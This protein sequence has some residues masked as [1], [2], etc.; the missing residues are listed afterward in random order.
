MTSPATTTTRSTATTRIA[1]AGKVLA[2]AVGLL[3][4]VVGVPWALITWLGNPV[5]WVTALASPAQQLTDTAVLQ[6]LACVVWIAWAHWAWCVLL[7]AVAMARGAAMPRLRWWTAPQH[8]LARTL[9]SWV[10]L[11]AIAIPTLAAKAPHT[12]AAPTPP[13]STPAIALVHASD[14]ATP[15]TS[16]T[17]RAADET[18]TVI[19][20]VAAT[21]HVAAAQKA[22]HDDG[23]ARYDVRRGDSLWDIAERHLGNGMRWREIYQLNAHRRQPDGHRLHD[24]NLIYPGW[25]LVL[26]ADATG[27]YHDGD[28][29]H[30]GDRHEARRH[31]GRD[32]GKDHASPSARPTAPTHTTA[33]THSSNRDGQPTASASPAPTEASTPTIGGHDQRATSPHSSTAPWLA[34]TLAAGVLAAG[35]GIGVAGLRRRQ[36]RHRRPGRRIKLPGPAARATERRLRAV[37]RRRAVDALDT[38]LRGLSATLANTT[39][40]MPDP[41]AVRL[42][43]TR[44]DLLLA[45]EADAPQ[46]WQ[47]EGRLWHL[48]LPPEPTGDTN[49]DD[50]ASPA[51]GVAPLLTGQQDAI[52][53][54][55]ALATVGTLGEAGDL[56]MLD[57][58]RVG[59]LAVEGDRAHAAGLLR[60]LAAEL[61]WNTWSDDVEIILVGDFTTDD[62]FGDAVADQLV[63]LNPERIR[64]A[65]TFGEVA[66]QIEHR[67]DSI[68]EILDRHD[69][70]DT[71]TGRVRDIAT[72][73]WTPQIVILA[74]APPAGEDR[75]RLDT[76]AQTIAGHRGRASVAVVIAGGYERAAWAVHVAD[77]GHLTIPALHITDAQVHSLPVDGIA[78]LVVLLETAR[79]GED[80]P[81]LA[82]RDDA[83]WAAG[84][85]EAGGLLPDTAE[86][87]DRDAGTSTL[88][89]LVRDSTAPGDRPEGDVD[90][91]VD[92][93]SDRG[94]GTTET[95]LAGVEADAL[96]NI[97]PWPTD[98]PADDADQNEEEDEL[99]SQAASE[100]TPRSLPEHLVVARPAAGSAVPL[101]PR[102]ATQPRTRPNHD[103]RLDEDLAAWHADTT[104]PKIHLLGRVH[105][106]AAGPPPERRRDLTTE[107]TAYLATRT[108]GVTAGELD[109]AIWP[110]ER[111][112]PSYRRSLLSG[113][114]KWL[115][116]TADGVPYLPHQKEGANATS[117]TYAL[118]DDV[119]VDW[120]LFRRL[121]IHSGTTDADTVADI[122]AALTLVTGA[123]IEH[124]RP[125]GYGW[126]T[127]SGLQHTMFAAVVDVAHELVNLALAD[128]DTDTARW[129]A[130][131]ARLC[132]IDT[133]ADSP[134]CDLMRVAV[135]EDNHEEARA[136]AAHLIEIRDLEVEED[137]PP[138]T[139]TVLNELHLLP[140]TG[141]R[142]TG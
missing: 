11:A 90:D 112:S 71:F 63:R 109:T 132:D 17:T 138:A 37:D 95:D 13:P 88:Y 82:A 43:A 121:R 106:D 33:P 51:G 21:S 35:V 92:T 72:D 3:V 5:A 7:E 142:A 75:H 55:P 42:G 87:D 36:Y 96:T 139:Y 16:L 110:D 101:E 120:Q 49:D 140:T 52:A 4:T 124:G 119:L 141:S 47:T 34:G 32:H 60:A 108:R 127:E 77:D 89:T 28:R 126:L 74:A 118:H 76:V 91:A 69:L 40:T 84:T 61:A 9:I 123:P 137:L 22:R 46:P 2:G 107:I 66:A 104:R 122:R 131:Q 97:D 105:V 86:V 30:G 18:A 117:G 59:V 130:E 27:L 10:L 129:A 54:L 1:T 65:A 115:G 23:S 56:L 48:E 70:P 24:A 134:L 100:P 12:T 80:E 135:A 38:G 114:R 20:P 113:V 128:D 93:P 39:A 41:V 67:L 78:A 50:I 26:P 53:P 102:R 83:D 15:E 111:R 125:R 81:I 133:T 68:Q 116:T 44:L 29:H 57:L 19:D 98:A 85:D 79:A 31:G 25:Q 99:G 64:H 103:P 6:I 73:T 14:T 45:E 58:E 62:P 94:T 136:L 8:L